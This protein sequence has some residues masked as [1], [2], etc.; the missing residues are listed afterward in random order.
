MIDELIWNQTNTAH[1]N[2]TSNDTGGGKQKKCP[3]T[4]KQPKQTKYRTKIAVAIFL[5]LISVKYRLEFC[6]NLN[7]WK[8]YDVIT[9]SS[10]RNLLLVL[11]F[12][13]TASAL[14]CIS[15]SSTPVFLLAVYRRH[16]LIFGRKKN[17]KRNNCDL[18]RFLVIL[19]LCVTRIHWNR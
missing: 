2:H 16:L 19:C 1:E 11:F 3:Y 18:E 10:H 13:S 5:S 14:I 4:L 15:L 6:F 8:Y 7:R 17:P 12:T 9:E